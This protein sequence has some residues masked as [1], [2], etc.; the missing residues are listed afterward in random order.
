MIYN[1]GVSGGKDSD[2]ALLWLVY[3][4]GIP[5]Q[6]IDATFCD[7]GNEHEFTYAHVRMLSEKVHPIVWL[8][9]VRDFDE[10][11]LWKRRFPSVKARFCT[12]FLKIEPTHYYL[13]GLRMLGNEVTSVSGVRADES[14]D[15]KNLT[16]RD[17][18][19]VGII[20]ETKGLELWLCPQ[21]RPLIK[22]TIKDVF[23][24][25]KEFDV[26]LNPLYEAGAQRVGCFPCIMSRKAEIRNIAIRYPERIDHIRNLEQEFFKRYGRYSSFFH[27]KTVPPR[28]RS[29]K[30]TDKKGKTTM[31]ATI[32]DV[33]KWAMSG[34]R[35]R[36]KW[37][38]K[39]LFGDY[40]SGEPLSCKS[41]FCE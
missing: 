30:Y 27:A 34:K 29:M 19:D 40:I 10:L 3:K 5:R 14:E 33:V 23:A 12:Q 37:D 32:D 9:P 35:A 18:M 8:K 25:H 26:P 13:S 31:V 1:C 39:D 38:D 17:L 21:W 41:G 4:S 15:R 28:F 7:T 11:A 36:G 24:I 2:A 22:W 20:S 16:E 6:Q